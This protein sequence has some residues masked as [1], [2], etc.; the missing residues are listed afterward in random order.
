MTAVSSWSGRRSGRVALPRPVATEIA[1]S[2]PISAPESMSLPGAY[3]VGHQGAPERRNRR[4]TRRRLEVIQ[5]D[6]NDREQAILASLQQ[7]RLMTTRQLEVLHFHEHASAQAAARICRRVLA[8]LHELR[9]IEHL[10]RRVG[11]I[12]AGSAS[13]VWRVG[14]VG[15]RLL[16]QAS[17]DGVRQRRKE[18]TARYLDHCLTT[19]E[20]YLALVSATRAG[21]IELLDLETEPACWRRYLSAGGARETLKPDLSAVTAAGEYEDHWFIEVDRGTESLPTLLKKCAQ[22]ERYRR[23]GR[24]QADGGVFPLVVWLMPDHVRQS[25]LHAAVRAARALDLDLFRITT[26]EQFLDVIR[27]GAA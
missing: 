18:P 8:R 22:Y 19:A 16:R 10:K 2:Q 23:T 7:F 26:T 13:Y 11:G 17:G 27:G 12:R 4:V 3:V 24:E 21:T 20:S 6:L 1:V 14:E 5:R 9:V 25:R 15:D